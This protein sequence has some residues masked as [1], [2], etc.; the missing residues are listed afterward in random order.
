[1]TVS[2][3]TNTYNA[4]NRKP[5]RRRRIIFML[6]PLL[7]LALSGCEK[8]SAALPARTPEPKIGAGQ[9][10]TLAVATDLHYLSDKLTDEGEAFE[11]YVSAGDGKQLHYS[12]ELLDAFTDEMT[13]LAPDVL[14]LSGDLTNNGEKQSHLDL[15]AKLK[16]IERAGTRVYVIPGNHDLFNPWA[17]SFKEDKQ[18]VA[19]YISDA[20]FAQIYGQF[21]YEEAASRD[22]SSLSYLAE[23][24]EDVWLLMLDTSK[25]RD[26][27]KLGH[28]ETDGELSDATLKW[29]EDCG[30]LAQESGAR[31][32][33]VM[34]HNLTDHSEVVRDGFTLNNAAEAAQLFASLDMKLSLSGHVHIQNIA[35]A[36]ADGKTV[37]DVV[38]GALSVSPHRYGLLHYDAAERTLD[39]AARETDVQGWAER[40][41]STDG[42]LLHFR[43]YS[44]DFFGKFGYDMAFKRLIMDDTYSAEEV[45]AMSKTMEDANVS[46]FAGTQRIDREKIVES[47]GYGLWMEAEGGFMKPYLESIVDEENADTDN[48]KLE[49]DF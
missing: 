2:V 9:N 44:R 42:N 1:M 6:L 47:E 11:K 24:S 14:I 10:V 35:A 5:R 38:T 30:R 48:L 23:P 15:A 36:K 18:Y 49:I 12:E 37:Y 40:T 28:P 13:G 29:I 41:G 21:G 16:A 20:Q 22:D 7:A 46:Y 4:A 33:P 25:Y 27:T 34:H 31:I 17:R 43:Q 3:T 8:G 39:Y 45:E 32:I 26:N 19:D